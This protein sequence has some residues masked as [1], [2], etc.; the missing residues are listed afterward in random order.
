MTLL[1]SLIDAMTTLFTKVVNS[2]P[3]TPVVMDSIGMI[4]KGMLTTNHLML[5]LSANHA[6]G[7]FGT[8]DKHIR[9]RWRKV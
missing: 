1:L 7:M 3:L 5:R 9:K 4:R 2:R 8:K 6:T